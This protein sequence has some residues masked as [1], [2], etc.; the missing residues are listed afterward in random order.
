VLVATEQ[1]LESL[2]LGV[3]EQVDAGVQGP[4]GGVQR[5]TG[6]AAVPRGGLLDAA[7]AL[8]QGVP[9]QAH[10]MKGVMRMSA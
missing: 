3:G 2:L 9:A 5:V 10:H 7:A 1:V 6:T 4:A 8:I